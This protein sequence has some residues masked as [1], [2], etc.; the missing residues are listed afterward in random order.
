MPPICRYVV[1]RVELRLKDQLKLDKSYRLGQGPTYNTFRVQNMS[2][3]KVVIII[4]TYNE[5]LV[6]E[7]TIRQVFAI[8]DS[9]EDFD[10]EILIFDSASTD[11]TQSKVIA[12]K[13]EFNG[14]HLQVETA[15]TGLGS[16]YLK[17]MQ[18]ALNV[19]DAAIVIEFDADLSHQ[20]KYLI[21]M[22]TQLKSCDVVVGSRYVRGGSIPHNWGIHRKFLSVLGN[23]VARL[24]LT[25]RYKDFTSGFRATRRAA[26][27]KSLPTK[28]LSN[29]YAYK[30]HLMW[31]L[32]RNGAHIKETPIHFIDR[33]LGD[34]K[35]PANS[36]KDALRVIFILRFYEA[37]NYF[38]MCLVGLS[39][40]G[41]QMVVYHL[42]RLHC[43]PIYAIK[44]STLLAIINNFILNHR[45]TF[46]HAQPSTLKKH[47]RRIA[48]FITYYLV[49][50][51]LQSYSLAAGIHYW[52]GGPWLETIL[53]LLII[54]VS[55][56]LNYFI[57]SRYIWRITE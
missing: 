53:L 49:M 52:G 38:K 24:L 3:E 20:P 27:L 23:Y 4:P 25:L 15:K 45:F 7:E 48:I 16:A 17:A 57:S 2:K 43:S 14:L 51:Q 34:S 37:K 55:S 33:T 42:L 9:L 40:M 12:L 8:T 26:L 19:L 41:L 5:A 21:P 35:L 50:I 36:I 6:I 31:L 39:G 29:H 28:F 44:V 30:L 32:H 1:Q 13:N 10:T 18:Y 46:K 22:L 56:L 54:G 11:T 47:L